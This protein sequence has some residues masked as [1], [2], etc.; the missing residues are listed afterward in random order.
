[1]TKKN[2]LAENMRR[3]GTKNL[4]K[5]EVFSN[6]FYI[7][8]GISAAG[9]INDM[10]FYY[11]KPQSSMLNDPIDD[12]DSTDPIEGSIV[13]ELLG[14]DQKIKNS[15]DYE[16]YN[17]DDYVAACDNWYTTLQKL[18]KES[19]LFVGGA[20]EFNEDG[21]DPEDLE[22]EEWKQL[23]YSDDDDDEDEED[24]I[25]SET[26]SSTTITLHNGKV[27]HIQFIKGYSS[28][29]DADALF[30]CT[31]KQNAPAVHN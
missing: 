30:K 23:Q 27:V 16:N 19:G 28:I 9:S 26:P 17:L 14:Y 18:E 11:R 4:M 25:F 10:S 3:F 31:V 21:N 2:I 24:E 1:M 7:L 8:H 12:I 13:F 22:G 20:W 6:T 15:G 29:E 5:E